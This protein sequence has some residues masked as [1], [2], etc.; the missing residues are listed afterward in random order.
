MVQVDFAFRSEV[1][2][3][4]GTYILTVT[5][6]DRADNQSIPHRFIYDAEA[7]TIEAVSH[8]DLTATVS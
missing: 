2:P 5:L 1:L 4:D 6:V 3:E 7:P 8:I